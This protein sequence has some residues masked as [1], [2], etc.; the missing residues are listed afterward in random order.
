MVGVLELIGLSKYHGQPA[1]SFIIGSPPGPPADPN[2]EGPPVGT[3]NMSI[4]IQD[5]N[6]LIAPG[7][8]LVGSVYWP[9]ASTGFL[10]YLGSAILARTTISTP[11]GFDIV[12]ICGLYNIT[13]A[14]SPSYC[15]GV[16]PIR[17]G[18][19][20]TFSLGQCP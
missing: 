6:G 9:G 19:H 15:G 17:N 7:P 10:G 16:G 12:R 14:F 4:R 1:V 20:Q 13:G 11:P 8:N 5:S 18:I 3:V 2:V